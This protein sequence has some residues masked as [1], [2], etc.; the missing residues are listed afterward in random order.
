MPRPTR[1]YGRP[2][3]PVIPADWQE[4]HAPVAQGTMTATVSLRKP[5]ST[6]VFDEATGQTEYTP[7]TPYATAQPAR[8]Q[9]YRATAIDRAKDVAD[10]TVRVTGYLVSVPWDNAPDEGD[11]VDVT[12][13][14]DGDLAGRSLVV[15]D[16]V[17]GSLR[18]TRDLFCTLHD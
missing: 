7:L 4:S 14:K 12:A 9:A 13:S 10:E 17:R 15:I 16:V 1:S 2:G 6:T 8:I 5:G 18:F 11:I 3:T